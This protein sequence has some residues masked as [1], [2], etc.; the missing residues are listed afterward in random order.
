MLT[1]TKKSSSSVTASAM[2]FVI[3]L[4]AGI[5]IGLVAV[6]VTGGAG[7]V[8]LPSIYANVKCDDLI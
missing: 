2:P 5:A 4:V 3:T 8:R 7:K 6:H 1:G